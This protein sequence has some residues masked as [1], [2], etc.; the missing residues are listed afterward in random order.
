MV[1]QQPIP[2]GQLGQRIRKAFV[3]GGL[4]IC[5][6]AAWWLVRDPA[7]DGWWDAFTWP[8]LFLYAPSLFFLFATLAQLIGVIW[9]WLRRIVN[10]QATHL[11][12]TYVPDIQATLG[13]WLKDSVRIGALYVATAFIGDIP[14]GVNYLAAVR[15]WPFHLWWSTAVSVCLIS[16]V[17]VHWL[18]NRIYANTQLGLPVGESIKG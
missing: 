11:E 18:L 10:R 15:R 14:M 6:Y 1:L 8:Q 2:N 12:P 7:W 9:E 16:M 13:F 4:F 17:L 3:A 5:T